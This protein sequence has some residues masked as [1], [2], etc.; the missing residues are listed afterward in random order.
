MDNRSCSGL[1]A[2]PHRPLYPELCRPGIV[3][4]VDMRGALVRFSP[5]TA[6]AR[7]AGA[8]VVPSQRID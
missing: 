8:R 4:R 1:L 2:C 7:V 3:L 6:Y 5:I